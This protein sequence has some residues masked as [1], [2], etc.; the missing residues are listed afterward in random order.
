MATGLGGNSAG[1]ERQ[2]TA[3]A[4]ASEELSLREIVERLGSLS[5]PLTE[6]LERIQVIGDKLHGS[7][8][9]SPS[10]PSETPSGILYQLATEVITEAALIADIQR[11]LCDVEKGIEG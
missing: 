9:R 3:P 7:R 10:E 5:I 2:H 6:I 4:L 11:A 8:P 1:C